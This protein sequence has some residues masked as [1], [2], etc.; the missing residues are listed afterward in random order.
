MT[1]R[2]ILRC[3][4][5]GWRPAPG[6]WINLRTDGSARCPVCFRVI[7]LHTIAKPTPSRRDRSMTVLLLVQAAGLLAL[8]YLMLA[9]LASLP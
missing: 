3:V 9:N 6:V 4:H 1:E 5:C 2:S 7:W 8:L